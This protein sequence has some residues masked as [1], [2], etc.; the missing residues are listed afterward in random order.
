MQRDSSEDVRNSR[1]AEQGIPDEK[2]LT[3]G[4]GKKR[5]G[6][7]GRDAKVSVPT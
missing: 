1:A 3:V 4:M 2:A 6:L 7:I 5:K